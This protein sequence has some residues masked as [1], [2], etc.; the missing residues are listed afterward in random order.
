MG[1][2]SAPSMPTTWGGEGTGRKRG[3]EGRV[4]GRGEG[5]V[6]ELCRRPVSEEARKRGAGNG[7][8]LC[9]SSFGGLR[10]VRVGG[11]SGERERVVVMRG[12]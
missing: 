6:S 7:A 5:G 9:L 1:T 10:L 3:S 8:G 4:A 2:N 11:G 12:G